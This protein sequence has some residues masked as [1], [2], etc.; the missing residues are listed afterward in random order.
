MNRI[1]F[2]ALCLILVIVI[3]GCSRKKDTFINRN[4]HAVNTEFNTLYNG[5]LALAQGKEQVASSYNENFWEILPVERMQFSEEIV[6]PGANRNELFQAAEVKATKAIQKHSMLIAG[7]EKNPQIDEAYLLLGKAR[8]YDQRFIPALEAFNY[9]LFKYPA[10]NTINHAQIWREKT[11]IRLQ[12]TSL[13]IKNL[14]RIL[15]AETLK[16]QDL[17]DANAMLAQ[18]YINMGSLDS[19]VVP[20]RKAAV[21]TKKDEEKGRYHFIEGQLYNHLQKRDSA[22]FA[23]DKV[24]ELNRKIPREYLIHAELGK[25]RNF[26]FSQQDHLVLYE[27]LKE[28]EEDRENRLFLDKIYFQFA[29]YYKHLDSVNLAT[30]Y[31]N[32]SLKASSDDT[33]L[34]SVNYETLGNIYFENADYRLAGTYY[35]STLTKIPTYTRD[36]F[37]IKRKR[38]NLQEVIQYEDIAEK[39]DSILRLVTMSDEERLDFFTSYTEALKQAAIAEAKKGNIPE[40]A[41]IARIPIGPGMPPALG[42]PNAGGNTFYFYN[43]VRVANGMRDFL[44]T[45]GSRELKD[46]WRLDEGNAT[47]LSTEELDN[48]SSLIIA[49]NPQFDPQ[50]Y[51]EQVPRE[52]KIIDSL[53]A[54]RNDAYYRL[55]LIYKEKFGENELASDKFQALLDYTFEE[56]LVV[57]STYYLYQIYLEEGNLSKAEKYKQLVLQN[58]GDSRYAASIRNPGL[59]VKLDDEVENKYLELYQLFEESNYVEVLEQSETYL[60]QYRD[61][62]IL[63]KISLLNAMATGRLYGFEAYKEALLKVATNYPQTESGKKAQELYNTSLPKLA[64]KEFQLTDE[65]NLKLLYI[66][67]KKEE[68]AAL[69]LKEK[70]ELAIADLGYSKLSTSVD[71]YDAE[72]IFVVVHKVGDRSK[73]EGFSEL[74]RINN[75]YAIEK[76]PVIITSDNYRIIQ[77]HK[78]LEAYKELKEKQ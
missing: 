9:I 59:A 78:N 71:V 65:N 37:F 52:P 2:S 64:N 24:T 75:K 69:K 77:L 48:V 3:S 57:P 22:N 68:S 42:G 17:A 60:E 36:Y 32:K 5:N 40:Q 58:Y 14:K 20:I 70:I 31:Y 51:L 39:N 76:I 33:F 12:N 23:F 62:D 28:L 63:P 45:W 34:Q 43:P 18:A 66:F 15:K 35:D 46:N 6:L 38:D 72:S 4:W 47:N 55:G 25:L 44:Q 73:A 21:F 29:E 13:A 26:N 19:A 41:P 1:S 56:R 49:N 7:R 67:N 8:Y 11:N 10:G 16:N 53:A 50:T 74:L 30:N 61:E 54:Q 27:Q